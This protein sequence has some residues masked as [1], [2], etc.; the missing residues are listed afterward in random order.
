M[1][2]MSMAALVAEAMAVMVDEAMSIPAIAVDVAMSMPAIAVEVPISI[3]CSKRRA[4][5]NKFHS[6][7]IA[8]FL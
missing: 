5:M 1:E 8:S 7:L 2:S 3:L 4:T 6:V